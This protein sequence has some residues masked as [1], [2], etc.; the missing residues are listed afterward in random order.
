M[1]REEVKAK[2]KNEGLLQKCRR[3]TELSAGAWP[4]SMM[5]KRNVNCFSARMTAV[6]LNWLLAERNGCFVNLVIFLLPTH[7]PLN[8]QRMCFFVA[9]GEVEKY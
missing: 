8:P 6:A 5:C 4:A 2:L 7:C 9:R 3:R 1:R